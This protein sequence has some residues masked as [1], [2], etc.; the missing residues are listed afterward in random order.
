LSGNQTIDLLLRAPFEIG[1]L[2]KPADHPRIPGM[3]L[4]RGFKMSA[5]VVAVVAGFIWA[6]SILQIKLKAYEWLALALV[7]LGI[8]GLFQVFFDPDAKE[9]PRAPRRF[10][11]SVCCIIAALVGLYFDSFPVTVKDIQTHQENEKVA[12]TG[13]LQNPYPFTLYGVWVTVLYS[14]PQKLDR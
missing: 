5:F 1:V 8:L 14:P 13:T 12:V 6:A 3:G 9:D 11:T 7:V 4:L 2:Q 10:A